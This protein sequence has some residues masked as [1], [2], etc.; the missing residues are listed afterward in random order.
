MLS[1]FGPDLLYYEWK[2]I[3]FWSRSM[4]ML[5]Y[6]RSCYSTEAKILLKRKNQTCNAVS[7][8]KSIY[9][10]E[11]KELLVFWRYERPFLR[12]FFCAH[13]MAHLE[14]YLKQMYICCFHCR[15]MH[16]DIRDSCL[17][18]GSFIWS[19]TNYFSSPSSKDRFFMNSEAGKFWKILLF[20]P[21]LFCA[22]STKVDMENVYP[23]AQFYG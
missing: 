18:C 23:E 8:I 5:K 14:I 15:N 11:R 2:R 3:F 22:A 6:P 13:K 9:L 16:R 19:E 4:P 1:P 20:V 17:E 10:K 12:I 7:C 21:R